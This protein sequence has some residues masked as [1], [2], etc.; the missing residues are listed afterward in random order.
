ML[1]IGFAEKLDLK[2][3]AELSKMFEEEKCCNGIKS[4]SEMFFKNKNVCVAKL[5][6][7]IIG[8]CYGTVETKKRNTTYYNEGDKSFYIEEIY[9]REEFRDKEIGSKLFKFIENYAKSLN[10]TILETTAVSKDYKKLLKFYINNH[11]M[12]FW[13]ANLIKKI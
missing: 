6:N 13:S 4:D 2:Q 3:V 10:C 9:I 1:V 5:D 8:Y 7:M 12:E 11:D